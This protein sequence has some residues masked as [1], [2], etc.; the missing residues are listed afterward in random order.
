LVR[1]F[2]DFCFDVIFEESRD[3]R[4]TDEW[5]TKRLVDA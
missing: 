3:E 1:A 4:S 2:D 5:K